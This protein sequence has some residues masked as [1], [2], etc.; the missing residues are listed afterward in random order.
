[1][2]LFLTNEGNVFAQHHIREELHDQDL[3]IVADLNKM[4]E[5]HRIVERAAIVGSGDGETTVAP[6]SGQTILTTTTKAKIDEKTKI[7]VILIAALSAGAVLATAGLVGT[8]SAFIAFVRRR[9][10]RI[11]PNEDKAAAEADR[12]KKS[13]AKR[14]TSKSSSRNSSSSKSQ[15]SNKPSSSSSKKSTARK[16]ISPSKQQLSFQQP[17]KAPKTKYVNEKPGDK[18]KPLLQTQTQNL[19]QPRN[20]NINNTMTEVDV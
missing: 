16:P 14:N 1:L 6:T 13:S 15:K 18:T 17:A 20:L 19:N 4:V 11:R 2:Y 3:F 7:N 12:S 9:R 8:A 10:M 5:P